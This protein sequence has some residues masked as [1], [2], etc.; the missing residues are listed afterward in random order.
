MEGVGNILIEY[1]IT[2]IEHITT[3]NG[4]PVHIIMDRR[5]HSW[6]YL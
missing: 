2:G 5:T 6:P 4:V 1:I 3:R